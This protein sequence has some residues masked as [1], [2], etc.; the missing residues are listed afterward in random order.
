MTDTKH[1]SSQEIDPNRPYSLERD[2]FSRIFLGLGIAGLVLSL[3][4]YFLEPERFYFSYLAAFAYW[5]TLTLGALFFTMLHHVT[6]A[7][8]SVVLRR[9]AEALT[10]NLPWLFISFLPVIVGIHTL[11]HWSHADAVAHDSILEAKSSYLNTTFFVARGV[12]YFGI[13][14]ALAF[15]LNRHSLAQDQDG[16]EARTILLRRISAVG[17]AAFALTM[18][19]AAVDWLM[20]LDPHWYSTIFGVF[21]FV[22]GFLVA[23]AFLTLF[24]VLSRKRGILA[25]TVGI[26]HFQDLGRLLFAFTVF[27]AYIGGSQ[28]FLIWYANI[29]EETVFFLHRW[30]GGWKSVSLLIVFL[31]FLV[32]FTALIF[33]ASK[34]N[35]MLLGAVATLLMVMHYVNMYWLVM[36]TVTASSAMISWVDITTLMGMGGIL[37]W[38]FLERFRRNPVIPLRDP[39]LSESLAYH[40]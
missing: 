21:L 4:G 30:E 26:K 28:Y 2:R 9:G 5:T 10:M 25:G 20:S 6:G 38:L 23:T 29:P 16:A 24:Y 12:L 32:P 27:W 39:D 8:W 33:F 3:L 15:L 37:V 40:S 1:R 13:W 31:H 18:T 7:R 17:I 14:T 19:F 11:Y 36:P 35:K 34:R 22:S